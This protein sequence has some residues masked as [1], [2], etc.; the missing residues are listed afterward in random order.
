MELNTAPRLLRASGRKG[1]KASKDLPAVERAGGDFGAG[2]IRGVSVITRGAAL[3]HG[4][5]IDGTFLDQVAFSAN[6]RKLGIKSR[7]THPGLSSDGMGTQL[8]RLKN[9]TRDGDQV[10]ADLHFAKSSHQTP[11]GDLADYVM[12]L[13]EETPEDFG[14]SIVFRSDR[15]AEQE[16][17]AAHQ[18]DYEV[19]DGRGKK[20]TR[21]RFRSP[22]A[23]NVENL[24][25][26]RLASLHAGDVVDSPAANAGGLF[27]TGGNAVAAEADA[28]AAFC[29]GLDGAEKP[30]TS[31]LSAVHP[32]RLRAFAERFLKNHKLKL[33][34]EDD[35]MSKTIETKPADPAADPRQEFAASLKRYTEKFGA[36]LG[37]QYLA[38]G[39]SYEQAL[40]KFSAHQTAQLS[41][42][43]AEA[44]EAK[45][46]LA[47]ASLGE[48]QPLPG[49]DAEKKAGSGKKGLAAVVRMK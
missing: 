16:F 33:I 39:L 46:R 35:E 31:A 41:A 2:L 27:S 44:S 1:L 26:Y 22:D 18:E 9:A 14:L 19:E 8:G 7:F 3:G 15:L 20:E 5:W 42:A 47:A 32:D 11:D 23:D 21:S 38:E 30:A 45:T 43:Q 6:Q 37:S 48:Q 29:L 40:E 25:H 34:S 13:A 28:L 17:E 49:G 10:F 4:G 36:E 12:S 24:P